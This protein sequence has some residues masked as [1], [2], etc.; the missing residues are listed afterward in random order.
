M[1]LD[2]ATSAIDNL[3]EEAVMKS[4]LSRM[5]GRT[6]LAVAHRLD[7]IRGFDEIAVMK[8]GRIVERGAFQELLNRGGHFR[9]LYDRTPR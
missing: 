3:T 2:E 6:V 4:V 8:L 7:S 9:E 1:I 5:A